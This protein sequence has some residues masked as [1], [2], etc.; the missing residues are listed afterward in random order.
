MGAG[1]VGGSVVGGGSTVVLGGVGGVE[2][3]VA[4]RV[5]PAQPVMGRSRSRSDASV[6]RGAGRIMGLG[7]RHRGGNREPDPD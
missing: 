2:L 3:G 4:V 7:Y 6:A 1:S 5:V